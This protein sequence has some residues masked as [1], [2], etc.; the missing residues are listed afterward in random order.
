MPTP[1]FTPEELL[2][3]NVTIFSTTDLASGLASNSALVS[4]SVGSS[5]LWDNTVATGVGYPWCYITFVPGATLAAALTAGTSYQI[6][7][8]K[9]VDGTDLE[10]GNATNQPTRA[11]DVVMP[12]NS[13]T[14]AVADNTLVAGPFQLPG[15]KMKFLLKNVATGQLIPAASKF[16]LTPATIAGY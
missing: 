1:L 16:V 4:P 11:P 13:A 5:G 10:A 15:C 14:T 2:G 7:F 6:W 9:Q 8:L 3:S 12:V